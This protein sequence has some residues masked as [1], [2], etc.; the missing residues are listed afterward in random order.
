M[1][2]PSTTRGAGGVALVSTRSYGRNC[3][4]S[5]TVMIAAWL[6]A[7]RVRANFVGDAINGGGLSDVGRRAG[8]DSTDIWQK[9]GLFTQHLHDRLRPDWTE[10][11][12]ITRPLRRSSMFGCID[13]K[14][15]SNG[16]VDDEVNALV[17][18]IGIRREFDCRPR[19]Q[20]DRMTEGRLHLLSRCR[21]SCLMPIH[22]PRY[23]GTLGCF[24]WDPNRVRSNRSR[25]LLRLCRMRFQTSFNWRRSDG[26]PSPSCGSTARAT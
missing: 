3:R 22:R 6:T 8:H 18:F 10:L 20:Q 7:C 16:Y 15:S 21:P 14:K 1:P 19:P 24:G 13:Q 25:R 9:I 4:K 23:Y 11:H 2:S 12:P 17:M 26:L 5:I